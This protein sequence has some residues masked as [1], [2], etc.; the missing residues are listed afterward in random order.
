MLHRR[1]RI[2]AAMRILPAVLVIA[3]AFSAAEAQ[4]GDVRDALTARALIEKSIAYHDPGGRWWTSVNTIELDQP[5]PDGST[6]RTQFRLHPGYDFDLSGEADGQ[7]FAAWLRDD[8][9]RIDKAEGSGRFA[10]MTCDRLRLMRDYYSYLFS[11][12][13]NL[14]D[15]SGTIDPVV[16]EREFLGKKVHEIRIDYDEDSPVWFFFFDPETFALVGT[17]FS[18]GGLEKDGEYLDYQGEIERD[19]VRLPKT[20][21][22]WTWKDHTKLGVDDI[23]SLRSADTE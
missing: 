23:I 17:S 6:T 18:T 8:E 9:C 1:Q 15:E 21:V 10:S 16:R 13:M 20:R 2:L 11:A 3:A 4:D 7:T 22:W 5:R 14:L 12:P 19:G